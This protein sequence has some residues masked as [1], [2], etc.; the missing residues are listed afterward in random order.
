MIHVIIF[1][2]HRFDGL[3]PERVRVALYQYVPNTTEHFQDLMILEGDE[4]MLL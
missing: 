2:C 1:C 4:K 3:L